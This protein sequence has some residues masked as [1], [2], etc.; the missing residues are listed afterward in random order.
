MIQ[1]SKYPITREPHV[2]GTLAKRYDLGSN[3]ILHSNKPIFFDVTVISPL[4]KSYLTNLTPYTT[5]LAQDDATNKKNN[6][7]LPYINSPTYYPNGADFR[8]LA[9]SNF[10]GYSTQFFELL[11]NISH[12]VGHKPPTN[13]AFTAPN[14][15]SYWTQVI[16]TTIHSGSAIA[17]E[18]ILNRSYLQDA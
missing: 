7:Y 18:T 12:R 11:A 3:G 17:I 5:R 2:P 8:P 15:I 6:K 4:Q 16:S 1:S 13:A 9:F 14:F 10:G